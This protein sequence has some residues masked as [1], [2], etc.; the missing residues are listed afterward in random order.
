VR[1]SF[2]QR[3]MKACE[4][5]Y[6]PFGRSCEALELGTSV[7]SSFVW[8]GASPRKLDL[9]AKNS[10]GFSAA[11]GYEALRALIWCAVTKERMR[12]RL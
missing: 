11:K 10:E 2:Q 1:G 8:R 5:S 4:T 6:T 12:V 3:R 7:S 9:K